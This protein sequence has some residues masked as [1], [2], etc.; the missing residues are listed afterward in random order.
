MC[1]KKDQKS[2]SRRRGRDLEK[3]K[4]RDWNKEEDGEEGV[5][6]EWAKKRQSKKSESETGNAITIKVT[7]HVPDIS[8]A[9]PLK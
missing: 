4:E 9:F 8:T 3:E 6:R 7:D 5:T 2:R 1:K